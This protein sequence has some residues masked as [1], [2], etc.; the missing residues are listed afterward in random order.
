VR[1]HRDS[2]IYF[3]FQ[4][5]WGEI[6]YQL[7]LL[8]TPPFKLDTAGRGLPL[9]R[10]NICFWESA[11]GDDI[12]I[13]AEKAHWVS[14]YLRMST[15]SELSAAAG[16]SVDRG[17]AT[18]MILSFWMSILARRIFSISFFCCQ[19]NIWRKPDNC[20]SSW[21]S[22]AALPWCFCHFG[23]STSAALQH[24]S[25]QIKNWFWLGRHDPKNNHYLPILRMDILVFGMLSVT[26]SARS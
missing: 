22:A 19:K 10:L 9:S 7:D 6:I 4:T 23:Y 11:V 16:R 25:W 15:Y 14:I 17:S 18:E 1:K 13:W 2:T 8:I 21:A 12:V 26:Q 5:S 24:P 20:S 3:H